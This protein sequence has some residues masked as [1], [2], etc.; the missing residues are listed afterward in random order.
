MTGGLDLLPLLNAQLLF[1]LLLTRLI[2]EI[3]PLLY[4]LQTEENTRC[5]EGYKLDAACVGF[6]HNQ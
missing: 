2:F 5:T 1:H 6:T 4:L 3:L